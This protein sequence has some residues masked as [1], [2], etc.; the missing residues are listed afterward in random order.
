MQNKTKNQTFNFCSLSISLLLFI[1]IRFL[2]IYDCPARVK[3][4]GLRRAEVAIVIWIR[5]ATQQTEGVWA[6]W[7]WGN[8]E[9][10]KENHHEWKENAR[11][12]TE[13][14]IKF[15]YKTSREKQNL[16]EN[17]PT[18]RPIMQRQAWIVPLRGTFEHSTRNYPGWVRLMWVS[19]DTS[20]WGVKQQRRC[21]KS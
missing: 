18:C 20:E 5:L 6:L 16:K 14:K 12:N 1:P 21:A 2:L 15:G 19:W 10:E 9:I 11:N 13:E 7:G 3:E 17:S 4:F 8:G